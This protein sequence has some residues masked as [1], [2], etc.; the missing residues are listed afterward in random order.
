VPSVGWNLSGGDDGSSYCL[1]GGYQIEERNYHLTGSLATFC[2]ASK[3]S[4]ATVDEEHLDFK[5]NQHTDNYLLS[6]RGSRTARSCFACTARSRTG[7]SKS[8]P[9][10]RTDVARRARIG[11]RGRADAPGRPAASLKGAMDGFKITNTRTVTSRA[12]APRTLQSQARTGRHARRAGRDRRL[13]YG[14]TAIFEDATAPLSLPSP[15]KQ[16]GA[17]AQRDQRPRARSGRRVV[18]A[19]NSGEM[20]GLVAGAGLT[21]GRPAPA[22]VFAASPA[23]PPSERPSACAGLVVVR[24]RAGCAR[25]VSCCRRTSADRITWDGPAG[26]RRS[27]PARRCVTTG[28]ACELQGARRLAR[29][30]TV[31]VFVIL[32]PSI[33]PQRS[34]WPAGASARPR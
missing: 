26:R 7:P 22:A 12:E 1:L 24:R 11:H 8:Q 6:K 29:L 15:T 14:L 31:R 16:A 10:E 17:A 4:I 3:G 20:R 18:G 28:R 9:G 2:G 34:R 27:R 5:F 32:K 30:V 25:A 13:D 23:A 21:L 19:G 33:A